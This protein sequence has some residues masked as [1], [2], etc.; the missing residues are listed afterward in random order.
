MLQLFSYNC[1]VEFLILTL[2]D[3]TTHDHTAL[4]HALFRQFDPS[5]SME[6]LEDRVVML[7]ARLA[8][9]IAIGA[10]GSYQ[11]STT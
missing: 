2:G 11:A 6:D 5:V 8:D 10:D 7:L 4:A 9:R 3:V 1:L